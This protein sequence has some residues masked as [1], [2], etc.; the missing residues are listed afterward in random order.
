M[1]PIRNQVQLIGNA[2]E[3]PE[4]KF[5]GKGIKWTRFFLATHEANFNGSAAPQTSTHWH[6][7]VAWGKMAELAGK[8]IVKGKDIAI[9]GRLV[10]RSFI[11]KQGIKRRISEVEITH[12]LVLRYQ[13]AT[14]PN[15]GAPSL[16]G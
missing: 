11:D 16:P 9:Q 8:L 14:E 3:T 1:N 13:P 6:A 5:V 2:R 12:I 7:L 4:V 10:S 15:F